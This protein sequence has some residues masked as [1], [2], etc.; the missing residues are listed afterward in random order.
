MATG[1]WTVRSSTPVM[2]L[3]EVAAYLQVHPSTIYRMLKVNAIP[4][5]K[6]GSDYRFS[7]EAIDAWVREGGA[8]SSRSG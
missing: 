3:R 5:F 8:K 4:A 2:T 1:K 6:I 7:Y